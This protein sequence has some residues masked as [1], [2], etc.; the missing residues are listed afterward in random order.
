M[1]ISTERGD[2]GFR[3]DALD[4]DISIWLNG[5]EQKNAVMA[6]TVLGVVKVWTKTYGYVE[7]T[8]HVE[9]RNHEG[10]SIDD[11]SRS[12]RPRGGKGRTG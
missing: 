4:L 9:I 3:E 12:K 2:P 5:I 1:R 8:G 6:D 11:A 10:K 7:H